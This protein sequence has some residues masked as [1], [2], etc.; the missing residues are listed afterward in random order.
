MFPFQ[1]E[2]IMSGKVLQVGD[3]NSIEQ[4]TSDR[5]KAQEKSKMDLLVND[6]G[7]IFGLSGNSIKLLHDGRSIPLNCKGS[8]KI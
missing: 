2:I 5:E 7:A 3:V 6:Y 1:G 8:Y 4:V